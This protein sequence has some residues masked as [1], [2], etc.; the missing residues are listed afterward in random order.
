MGPNIVKD[1]KNNNR[2]KVK[3]QKCIL[4]SA[5]MHRNMYKVRPQSK[6]LKVNSSLQYN[7]TV[8]VDLVGETQNKYC[9][10]FT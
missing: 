7:L 5:H 10:G 2:T 1:T 9:V 3:L 6:D 8:V 4:F